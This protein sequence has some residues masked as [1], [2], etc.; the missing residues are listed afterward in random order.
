MARPD[1]SYVVKM[2]ACPK[3]GKDQSMREWTDYVKRWIHGL[4]LIVRTG[5]ARSRIHVAIAGGLDGKPKVKTAW[6]RMLAEVDRQVDAGG[7]MPD[8]ETMLKE[9]K[10]TVVAE[11][12]TVAKEEFKARNKA[13][14]ETF[15]DYKMVL[16]AIGG[17]AYE[18]LSQEELTDK[19]KDRFLDGMGKAGESVRL[20]APATIEEAI[21][22]GIAWETEKAK[23]EGAKGERVYAFGGA[24]A[25]NRS[26]RIA[27]NCFKCGKKGHKASDCRSKVDN[28]TTGATGNASTTAGNATATTTPK[29]EQKCFV[30]GKTDHLARTCPDRK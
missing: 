28:S 24:S 17:T 15:S 23:Q 16:M 25:N 10:D 9:L 5:P 7:A 30:C 14:D 18:G 29:V 1:L 4:P 22:K 12:V 27:G 19:V 3:A 20:Q 8:L 6:Q 26:A 2:D 11:E 21:A 13:P